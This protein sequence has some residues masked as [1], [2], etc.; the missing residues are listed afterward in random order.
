[1]HCHYGNTRR[2]RREKK[3]N[4]EIQKKA[5]TIFTFKLHAMFV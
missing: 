3:I 2:K 5:E 4:N 1:M